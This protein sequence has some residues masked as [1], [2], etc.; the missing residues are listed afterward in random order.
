M[1]PE[2]EIPRETLTT[3]RETLVRAFSEGEVRNLCQDLRIDYES[4]PGEGK[5]NKVRELV[6]YCQRRGRIAEL[7]EAI[8]RY[9]PPEPGDL[10]FKGLAYFD[11]GDAAIFFGREKLTEELVSHLSQH[12]FLAVVGASGSGKS[13]VVRAGVIPAIKKGMVAWNGQ[14]SHTWP[15]HVITPGDEPLKALAAALTRDS[16]SVTATKTLL[17]DMQADGESLDFFLYRRLA[18]Q[19]YSRLLL[20]VDQLEELFT[21]CDDPD[22][23][24]LFVENLVTAV[25]SGKQGR[26][27]LILALRADFYAYAVQYETLRPLLETQQKIVGAM[28]PAELRQAIEGPAAQTEWKFQAGLVETILQD[29]GHEPGALPLL[30]HAL[31]ETWKKREGRTMTLAGYQAVGGV[32][33]AIATTADAV[34]AQL[35]LYQQSLARTIFLRLTELGEGTE[36]TRRRVLQTELV[37]R[38]EEQATVIDLLQTLVQARL[39]TTNTLHEPGGN[40]YEV[41]EVAHEA[42]IRQWPALRTWLDENRDWL[43]LHRQLTEAA[44]EWQA[45][46]RDSGYLYRGGQLAQAREWAEKNQEQLNEVEQV[47]LTA[48]KRAVEQEEARREALYQRELEQAR[49]LA[50]AERQARIRTFGA[51]GVTIFFVFILSITPIRNEWYRRQAQKVPLVQVPGGTVPLGRENGENVNENTGFLPFQEYEIE[52]FKIEAYEVT[53]QRYNFCVS[54]RTCSRPNMSLDV[55]TN[56]ERQQYP[57]AGVTAIQ[58]REFCQWIDREL[59]SEIQW[60]WSARFPDGRLWPWGS[61]ST[62]TP[63]LAFMPYNDLELAGPQK[64]GSLEAGKSELGIYDL[65]GNVWEWTRSDYTTLA[66]WNS[67]LDSPETLSVRGGGFIFS[68]GHISRRFNATATTPFEFIGFRCIEPD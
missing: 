11:E 44:M 40:V 28:N 37:R 65:V 54:A 10:P 68:I 1:L 66:E 6:E 57:V 63:S 2:E 29:V 53:N 62:P 38:P 52:G 41:V 46:G 32:R 21:Q 25:Q 27:S 20:V 5:A 16:E 26:L 23:R 45:E 50:K 12:R 42:L 39:V 3:L 56:P 43:R 9:F 47:F 60:E 67:E 59:P 15:V 14:R 8:R 30:S 22:E 48:S 31:Q 18:G 34:Y 24:Q 13:S 17:A 19:T 7:E 36:D 4:L 33:Q 61:N 64:V 58:A 51:L 55:Y 49:Q 35:P